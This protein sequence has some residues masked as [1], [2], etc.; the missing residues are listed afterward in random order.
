VRRNP[1]PTTPVVAVVVPAFNEAALIAE[2]LSSIP[3]WVHQVIVVDDGSH[4]ETAL[5]AG[6]TPRAG[7]T[8]VRHPRNRGVGAA[9]ATGYRIAFQELDADVVAVMAGDAQMD[10]HE[11]PALLAPLLEG[12]ADY[13][14]GNRLAFPEARRRMPFTRWLGNHALTLLT[15]IATGTRVSDSQCGYTALSRH[16]YGSASLDDLWPGYGY[17]NDLLGRMV[18]ARLRVEEVVVRPIYGRERSG[19]GWRHAL[20]IVP[21]VLSRIALRRVRDALTPQRR[22]DTHHVA[23]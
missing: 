8:L 9:I 3:D 15:R 21:Y 7:L 10:A 22:A 14:K 13:V 23:G 1:T 2:T 19:V 17:P 12:R 6:R 18:R 11:L 4:D 20:C 16:A 5:I